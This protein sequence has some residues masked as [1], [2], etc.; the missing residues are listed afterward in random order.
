MLPLYPADVAASNSFK[1]DDLGRIFSTYR[2][3]WHENLENGNMN[4]P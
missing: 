3:A 1:L 4:T 2:T